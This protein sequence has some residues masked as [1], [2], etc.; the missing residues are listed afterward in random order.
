MTIY[1]HMT[2]E[3][4]Y[5][6]PA[7]FVKVFSLQNKEPMRL[8]ADATPSFYACLQ[9]DGSG[10][11]HNHAPPDRRNIHGRATSLP[12]T[13]THNQPAT[14]P[15]SDLTASIESPSSALLSTQ[16]APCR[17]SPCVEQRRTRQTT[18]EAQGPPLADDRLTARSLTYTS[19]MLGSFGYDSSGLA[20]C[21][22]RRAT[23]VS[24]RSE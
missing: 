13:P 1:S 7:L 23:S 22:Q 5:N 15:S 4:L 2:S 20:T 18:H 21:C 8:L 24:G 19:D 14:L 12:I 10:T 9:T 11:L 6:F 16:K 3:S 17:M